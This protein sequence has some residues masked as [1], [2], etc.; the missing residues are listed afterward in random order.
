MKLHALY[1][2][3]AIGLLTQVS[4]ARPIGDA[5]G[6]G[7]SLGP[8]LTP[9][10]AIEDTVIPVFNKRQ[11]DDGAEAGFNKRQTDDEADAGAEAGFNKR[12]AD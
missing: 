11:A 5:S 6:G 9:V 3:F 4:Q 8:D 2:T 12:Q 7:V 10:D 1:I